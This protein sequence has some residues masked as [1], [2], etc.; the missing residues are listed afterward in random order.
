MTDGGDQG[1]IGRTAL[2]GLERL[3]RGSTRTVVY[4]APNASLDDVTGDLAYEEYVSGHPPPPG[5]DRA[6]SWRTGLA[7]ADRST[8]DDLCSWPLRRV[9]DD[10]GTCGVVVRRAPASFT[11]D[12][13]RGDAGDTVA[14]RPAAPRTAEALLRGASQCQRL[15]LPLVNLYDRFAVGAELARARPPLWW[16]RGA[17]LE[18]PRGRVLSREGSPEGPATPRR[19]PS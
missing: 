18:P 10:G 1:T 11:H 7:A 8:L 16:P 4:A 3:G 14:E 13:D 5:L 6:V 2:G 12:A 19:P 15:G 9:V 17:A